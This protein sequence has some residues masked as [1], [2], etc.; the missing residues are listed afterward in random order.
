MNFMRKVV[1]LVAVL[2]LATSA[3]AQ[4]RRVIRTPPNPVQEIRQLTR[5]IT[6]L[7]LDSYADEDL[8]PLWQSMEDNPRATENALYAI[9]PPARSFALLVRYESSAPR[10]PQLVRRAMDILEISVDSY[11]DWGRTWASPS[12]VYTVVMTAFRIGQHTDLPPDLRSRATTLWSEVAHIAALEADYG[13][14]IPLPPEFDS[15]QTGDTKA[16]EFAWSTTHFA[17]AI[18]ANPG[19]PSV[20]S[21]E[22][23]MRQMGYN[24]ITR[25]SDPPDFEG[26]KYTTV[27]EDFR[28]SNHDL[29]PNPFYTAATINLLAWSVLAYRLQGLDPPVELMHN[30]HPLYDVYKTYCSIT[31]SGEHYWNRPADAGDPTLFPLAI[32]GDTRRDLT[33]AQARAARRTLTYPAAA[34]PVQ[35]PDFYATVENHKIAIYSIF[36]LY[37]WYYPIPAGVPDR[38]AELRELVP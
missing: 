31:L 3:S 38:H 14:T 22:R 18:L 17:A 5:Q 24:A 30:M 7:V 27:T 15:S 2:T 33:L 10:D 28:L 32:M 19:H 35:A 23:R 29:S 36:G 16:E 21:W 12:V 9:I 34:G 13:L 4:R 20:P 11:D 25:P 37:L 6:G 1:F 26:W 8:Q